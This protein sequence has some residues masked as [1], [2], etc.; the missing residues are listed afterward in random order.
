MRSAVDCSGPHTLDWHTDLQS[1]SLWQLP[2]RLPALVVVPFND[3]FVTGMPMPPSESRRSCPTSKGAAVV[4][5]ATEALAFAAE[6]VFAAV[7]ALAPAAKHTKHVWES[8][9][10]ENCSLA[11]QLCSMLKVCQRRQNYQ[12][13]KP[14]TTGRMPTCSS[15]RPHADLLQRPFMPSAGASSQRSEALLEKRT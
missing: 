13:H 2:S 6:L 4:F 11:D 5:A 15:C 12:L 14:A 1:K 10:R 7:L 9:T 8:S 3:A